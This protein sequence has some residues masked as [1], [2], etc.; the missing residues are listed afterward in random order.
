MRRPN[1]IFSS[2]AMVLFCCSA[3]LSC[4]Y[5]ALIWSPEKS[6]DAL[7]RIVRDGKVGYIDGTGK[8]VIEPT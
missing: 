8:V 7:Y 1:W 5:S 3:A 6:A 2:V 4:E